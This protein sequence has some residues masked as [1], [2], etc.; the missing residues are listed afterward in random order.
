MS[1]QMKQGCSQIEE[2][3]SLQATPNT[4]FQQ[5]PESLP[6]YQ[7]HAQQEESYMQQSQQS[8][9]SS[10]LSATPLNFSMQQFLS[11]SQPFPFVD[12]YF[13]AKQEILTKHPTLLQN[14][15]FISIVAK[16]PSLSEIFLQNEVL[17][18]PYLVP[19]EKPKDEEFERMKKELDDF[20][21]KQADQEKIRAKEEKKRLKEEK[22]IAD[23]IER[24][25]EEEARLKRQKEE[26][27]KRADERAKFNENV[28]KKEAE[29]EQ[30]KLNA[31]LEEKKRKEREE[32]ELRR[33][34]IVAQLASQLENKIGKELIKKQLE[35]CGWNQEAARKSIEAS[36]P[37][38]QRVTFNEDLQVIS[39][40]RIKANDI[41]FNK[42]YPS[43]SVTPQQRLPKIKRRNNYFKGAGFRK[44]FKLKPGLQEKNLSQL[45]HFIWKYGDSVDESISIQQKVPWWSYF[46][47]KGDSNYHQRQDK[48]VEFV[49]F[50]SDQNYQI[51]MFFQ[52]CKFGQKRKFGE[53]FTIVGDQQL[54]KNGFLY[55]VW[56]ASEDPST[57]FEQNVTLKNAPQRQLRRVL[58]EVPYEGDSQF[59]M[60]PYISIEEDIKSQSVFDQ[61]K[62]NDGSDKEEQ[63]MEGSINYKTQSIVIEGEASEI[64]QLKNTVNEYCQ[65]PR[66]FISLVD[67]D[68]TAEPDFIAALKQEVEQRF[69]IVDLTVAGAQIKII[70]FKS[71]QARTFTKKAL[72]LR[73]KYAKMQRYPKYWKDIDSMENDQIIIKQV[74]KGSTEFKLIEEQ[75]LKTMPNKE[76]QKIERIQNPKIWQKFQVETAQMEKKLK[77]KEDTQIR[78]LYHGTS[79]NA[80]INIYQSE[81]GFN[82]YYSNDGMWGRANY[83]AAKASYSH[84]YRHTLPNGL[85]QMFYARVILGKSKELASDKSLKE[86]PFIEGSSTVRYDSVQ[87]FIK[88][89]NVFM[90]YSNCKAYPEYLITYREKPQNR[91]GHVYI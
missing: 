62:D 35:E 17:L 48:S 28:S 76:V 5:M 4:S 20:K 50:D 29:I 86:P 22:R 40:L 19:E 9:M 34:K 73:A 60:R 87:G 84:D 38:F 82:G 59:G 81:Q 54:A 37:K 69:K 30:Q 78:Y 7:L 11:M 74:D 46:V 15:K 57:W 79:A 13:K 80:P 32:E 27:Q 67:F 8:M 16:D 24:K 85:F 21:A 52:E 14:E 89:T 25:Q 42:N 90:V 77:S 49:E 18:K 51:E 26:D 1:Q 88:N 91:N 23:E 65:N 66:N 3:K 2:N 12:P 71:M 75:F 58:K 64:T 83:F 68:G 31:L 44:S 10:M 53:R 45:V 41:N 47:K 33:E 70:G 55:Q 6:L 61:I 43:I 56:G 36:M 39:F 72:C 63:A